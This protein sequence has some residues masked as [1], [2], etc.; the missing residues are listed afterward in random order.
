[1]VART[2]DPVVTSDASG[3]QGRYRI[4]LPRPT[5]PGHPQPSGWGALTRAFGPA[6]F[7]G[8]PLATVALCRVPGELT[9]QRRP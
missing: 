4:P 5:G 3:D 7:A 2:V 9:P 8:E 1:M 6:S